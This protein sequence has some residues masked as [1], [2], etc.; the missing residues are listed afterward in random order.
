[1]TNSERQWSDAR[2]RRHSHE[3]MQNVGT[4][5]FGNISSTA[6]RERERETKYEL[7]HIFDGTCIKYGYG[8]VEEWY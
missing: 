2:N 1:M 5:D 3:R 4:Y 7:S 6:T 8:E